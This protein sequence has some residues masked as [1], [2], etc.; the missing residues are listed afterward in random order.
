MYVITGGA[1]FIGSAFVRTLNDNGITN[2]IIV[3]ELGCSEKWKN[4]RG[5]SYYRYYHKDTFIDLIRNGALP[6]PITALVHMGACSS[7]TERDCDFLMR[8]NVDYST[9]LAD[10]AASH[11]TRFIY[12]SSAATYGG[13]EAGYSDTAATSALR[14]L[15]PYGYSKLV[16]DDYMVAKNFGGA[17][18]G[19]KFFNVYG[20]NEYH[21]ADMQSMV[22]KSWRQIKQEGRVKLFRSGDSRFPDGGQK[23]DFIYVKDCCRVIWWLLQNPKVTGIFNLGTGTAR[24]WN[25]LATAVFSALGRPVQIEYIEMPESIRSQYQNFTQ[26]EMHKLAAAGF[27]CAFS[28]LEQGV[29][30]YVQN[31]LEGPDPY[32]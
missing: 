10:Y 13:G 12:A 31:H 18:C 3:D 16:F 14:P 2:I 11:G 23:R 4:L 19:L 22:V 17:G 9:T 1:G 20:P 29:L 5:K 25:D 15:N 6:Y 26:A 7:T 24:S 28:S 8:N 27:D 21:K 32:F 30:D